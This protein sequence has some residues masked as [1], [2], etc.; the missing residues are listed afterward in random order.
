MTRN[1]AIEAIRKDLPAMMW[2]RDRSRTANPGY[3]C[4]ICGS[5]SG[6]KGTGI[7]TRDGIHFT[8][9][10]GCFSNQDIFSIIGQD[11]GIETFTE[12]L[13][14]CCFLYGLDYESL[15]ND[16]EPIR[17]KEPSKEEPQEDLTQYFQEATKHIEE[18][19]YL[20]H[21]GISYETQKKYWI[22]FV[23]EWKHPKAPN[24]PTSPRV[25]IPTS[26][27][28]YLARDTRSTLNG[29]QANYSKSKV[30]NN[31]FFNSKVL[32]RTEA[33]VFITEGEI[34]ALSIIEAGYEAVAL[35]S[36][37]MA[38]KLVFFLKENP[39]KAP[40]LICL[41][42]DNAGYEA[43]TKLHAK[44]TA[45]GIANCIVNPHEGYKD[46]NEALVDNAA[47]FRTKCGEAVDSFT[48][49]TLTEATRAQ[50][51]YQNEC[52]VLKHREQFEAEIE[53][54]IDRKAIPTGFGN[55]DAI[56]N[57]GLYAGL[58]SIGGISSVGKTAFSMQIADNIAKEETD[59]LVFALEMATNELIARSISRYSF[60]KARDL[61]GTT[62]RAKKTWQ[63]LYDNRVRS[64]STE[65]AKLL[66]VAKN[67]YF[68]E[69]AP[70]LYIHEGIGN[71]GINEIT[72]EVKKH[73]AITGN[74][75][76]VMID[77]LQI[78]APYNMHY[79]DKQNTDKA[80][81][82]LKRLSRDEGIPVVAVSSFNREGYYQSVSLA[83]FK[84]SGSI[85]YT[86]DVIIGIQFWGMDRNPEETKE[87]EYTKRVKAI[88]DEQEARGRE[89]NFQDIQIKVLKNRM[90]KRNSTRMYLYPAY[91]YFTEENQYKNPIV[92]R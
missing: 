25:I 45:L 27:T 52:S 2:K 36:V 5:G 50:E 4:P 78:L 67:S 62:A 54:N 59:V 70:R 82:E 85:E 37:N 73:I 32:F 29:D 53:A 34:D 8:C 77:Y 14:R 66:E 31:H 83:S 7:S 56:L 9:W 20:L 75:P 17:K 51:A 22:G 26:P 38:D 65:E 18:T 76:V 13:K 58:Y 72:Q 46:A 48:N 19:D 39:I 23:K 90:G 89:E 71:I 33:P 61:Y 88:M 47:A 57:G 81:I 6:K 84:E 87:T 21:R 44:L 55:L 30:G 42:N 24:A 60:L 86:S 35:G 69:V 80:V 16:N 12:Q 41:D 40:L 92:T 74:K 91:N 28:S 68:S 79:S 15:Q 11:E 63:V 1:E 64:T 10:A 43:K 3:I 49:D